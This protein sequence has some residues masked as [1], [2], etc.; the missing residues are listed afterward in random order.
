MAFDRMH[1]DADGECD[2][3]VSSLARYAE[4][5]RV[6]KFVVGLSGGVDSA[7][8]LALAA[9]TDVL[10]RPVFIS[11]DSDPLDASLAGEV[12]SSLK[13][14]GNV[15]NLQVLDLTAHH[16]QIVGALST[17]IYVDG[18]SN[19]ETVVSRHDPHG[20]ACQNTKSRLRMVALR[21]YANDEGA[22]LLGTTNYCEWVTGYF[23]RGGDSECD[24]E[25]IMHLYK[26]EILEMARHLGVPERI[27]ARAP[28]AGLVPG[29]TDEGDLGVT[30]A[31][32]ERWLRG[33][34]EPDVDKIVRRT[35]FKRF[36][37]PRFGNV[38]AGRMHKP[39][40]WGTDYEGI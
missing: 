23:T 34:P 35:A 19:L 36:P 12:W 37:P 25:P 40:G 29:Q 24:V 10:V 31:A 9:R 27:V 5:S 4:R 14:F 15:H 18:M 7:V 22:L 2:L 17:K 8:V 32:I 21:Y 28:T 30:Y 1:T 38:A 6:G 39:D 33:E 3:I 20:L 16:D 26:S 11:V 13:G